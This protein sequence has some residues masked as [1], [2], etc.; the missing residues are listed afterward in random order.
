[1]ETIRKSHEE[2]QRRRGDVS[3]RKLTNVIMEELGTGGLVIGDWLLVDWLLVDWLLVDWL[4]GI[5]LYFL[6]N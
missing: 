3:V 2:N 1:M 4:L 6:S 5:E